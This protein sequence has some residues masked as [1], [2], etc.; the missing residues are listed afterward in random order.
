MWRLR[1][2]ISETI[3]KYTPYKNDISVLI[4]HVPAFIADIDAIVQENYPDFDIVWFGHIGDGNLHLNILKPANLTKDEF[5]ANAKWLIRRCLKQCKS[6]MV[7]FRQN[8]V[9]V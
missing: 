7:L 9:W 5:L 6:T 1:E 2:D 8:M 4:T 3:A